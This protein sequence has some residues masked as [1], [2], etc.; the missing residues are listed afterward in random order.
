MVSGKRQKRFLEPLTMPPQPKK[1]KQ[2]DRRSNTCGRRVEPME[3]NLPQN[4]DKP[5]EV[6]PPQ[7]QE[8]PMEVD[9][10]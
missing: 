6:D 3:V 5:M 8:E 10:P 2:A 4:G 7:E 9:P 1:Q